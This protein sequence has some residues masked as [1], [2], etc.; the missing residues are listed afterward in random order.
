[1]GDIR[2]RLAHVEQRRAEPSERS[3]DLLALV[4][5][6]R[7]AA[8]DDHHVLAMEFRGHERGREHPA[9]GNDRGQLLGHFGDPVAVEPQ[10]L[11]GV[12][13]CPEDRPGED[14]RPDRVEAE[15]EIGDDAEVPTAASH[16]PEE[17]RVLGL[18]RL[19]ELSV[20][21]HQIDAQK[22]VDR[23][24]VLALEPTD[25]PTEG[26]P[27]EAGVGDDARRDRE[28]KGLGLA[29][30]LPQQ[31]SSLGPGRARLRIDPDPLHLPEIDH[32]PRVADR[33]AGIAVAAASKR[34]QKPLLPRES[35]SRDYVGD[36]GAA[37]D[38]C[39]PPVDRAVPDLALVVVGSIRGA[40]ELSA[41]GA[42]EFS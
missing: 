30:H 25:P 38:Q 10:H 39:R 12:L 22:L 35:H 31:H 7:I 24:P 6:P 8:A 34:D 1:M 37:R 41:E 17:V 33:Q 32:H 28:P 40:N 19:H 18:R 2:F 3:H 21:G 4:D 15:L 5:R 14:Q 16:T 20:R 29:I 11:G 23:Q 26:E 36:A 42:L 13:H 9:V 27:G